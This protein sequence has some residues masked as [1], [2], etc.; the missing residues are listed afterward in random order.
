MEYKTALLLK[1]WKVI[2]TS[3]GAVVAPASLAI[4]Y[5]SAKLK[6]N[7]LDLDILELERHQQSYVEVCGILKATVALVFTLF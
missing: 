5:H 1:N 4:G 2:L 3:V 6:F 7:R